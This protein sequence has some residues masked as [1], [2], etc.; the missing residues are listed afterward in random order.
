MRTT[1]ALYR[2]TDKRNLILDS[3]DPT[4]IPHIVISPPDYPYDGYWAFVQ[5]GC[6]PQ[7][8]PNTLTVPPV[9][10]GSSVIWPPWKDRHLVWHSARCARRASPAPAESPYACESMPVAP[11]A[12][13]VFNVVKFDIAMENAAQERLVMYHVIPSLHRIH[14]KATVI[15]AS[16]VALDFR[17]R[18]DSPRYAAQFEKPLHWTDQ[19]E[20][21]L[22]SYSRDPS[23]LVID[24]PRPCT[25]PHIVITEAPLQDPW[26]AFVNNTPNPQD[27]GYGYYLTV[28]SALV[29]HVNVAWPADEHTSDDPY[30]ASPLSMS[31]SEC[32]DDNTGESESG[33]DDDLESPLPLTP[34]TSH[35][36]FDVD[37]VMPDACRKTAPTATFYVDEDEEDDLPPFDDWYLDIAQRAIQSC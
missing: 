27:C 24:S 26:E 18:W 16:T 3:I 9:V 8:E 2:P 34:P 13:R 33:S 29:D 6:G 22:A 30:F 17:K 12:R 36:E 31:L 10:A 19:A 14:Y 23:S 20:A 15:L 28:P 32:S 11:Q 1:P 5:N 35:L 37:V 4:F 7:H 21:L 25:I